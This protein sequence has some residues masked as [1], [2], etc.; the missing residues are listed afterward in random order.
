MELSN[1]TFST[2]VTW[3]CHAKSLSTSPR[4]SYFAWQILDALNSTRIRAK[5]V[6]QDTQG[7]PSHLCYSCMTNHVTVENVPAKNAIGL[8]LLFG[9]WATENRYDS[10]Q[11]PL[12]LIFH[13]KYPIHSLP[14]GTV[15]ITSSDSPNSTTLHSS[16]DLSCKT[17]ILAD[18]CIAGCPLHDDDDCR[19]CYTNEGE[20]EL[21][22][23][24][25]VGGY[26]STRPMY[27]L[28]EH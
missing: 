4:S 13:A 9:S 1:V 16:A 19:S 27:V 18:A 26:G 24:I 12:P 28:P 21:C 8:E 20:G 6:M 22:T 25:T 23:V 2:V 14:L 5:S 17:G 3:V 15:C 11:L 10:P 7:S